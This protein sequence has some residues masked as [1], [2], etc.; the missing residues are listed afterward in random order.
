[1]NNYESVYKNTGTTPRTYDEAYNTPDY[2][3]ALWKC[4]T[5]NKR[6][7]KMI[8]RW[9]VVLGTIAWVLMSI[10]AMVMLFRG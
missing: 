2:A 10:Y 9:V 3:T 6:G 7:M 1:M 4:E 8:I 5:D